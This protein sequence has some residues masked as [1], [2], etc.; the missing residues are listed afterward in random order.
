MLRLT[1][2]PPQIGCCGPYLRDAGGGSAPHT[3]S[4]AVKYLG[5]RHFSTS[6][7]FFLLILLWEAVSFNISLMI[8]SARSGENDLPEYLSE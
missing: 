3:S 7:L 6:L 2:T 8:N 4:K 5:A 1:P